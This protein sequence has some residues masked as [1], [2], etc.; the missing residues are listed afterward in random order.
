MRLAFSIALFSKPQILIVDEALSVGDAHFSSKCTRALK[1]RKEENMSIIYVS[2]DLNSL[3]LLCDRVILLD[4][5][6]VSK[7]G[8]PDDVINSYNYLISKLNDDDN[9]ISIQQDNHNSFGTFD[10]K[11]QDTSII[12]KDSKSSTVSA[13]EEVEIK[14]NIDAFKNLN[15]MT[16]GIMIRDKF[17]QDIF[18][19][20]SFYHNKKI[21][22]FKDKLYTVSFKMLLNI[23][24]GKYSV[25]AAVHSRDTHLQNCSH[26]LDNA[27][28]FEVIGTKG[29][30]FIGICKL[31]PEI[32]FEEK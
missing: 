32:S 28:S 1:Q 21:S 8:K 27:A 13:G 6:K 22:F 24:A 9:Q 31:D 12:G 4:K 17:G 20:N 7:V 14:V 5:G 2:H 19:T 25:T 15:D 26:W 3:K 30:L 18:G 10:V 29:E 23:G 16:V 11:I